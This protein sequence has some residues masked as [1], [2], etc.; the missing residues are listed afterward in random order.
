MNERTSIDPARQQK[1]KEI[2]RRLHGGA[3]ASEVKRDFADLIRGVSA[4]EVASMEQA[5][6]D[7]GFPVEE[8]QRLCEVHVQVFESSLGKGRPP[9][10][11]PGHPVHSLMAE[12]R[13]A[14][15]RLKRLTALTRSGFLASLLRIGNVSAAPG[16]ASSRG[17]AEASALDDLEKILIH[18]TRKENQLFPYLEKHGFTGPSKVM[19]GKHDEIRRLF[20]EARAALG[21]TGRFRSEA[22]KLAAAIRRMIFMEERILL[23]E[24]LRKLSEREWAEIRGGED[25]IGF[26]WIRP[27][28]EYDA[29]IAWN[30]ARTSSHPAANG[31]AASGQA[32]SVDLAV[33]RIPV[34]ILDIALKRLPFDLS[35]VDENNKV[36]Y[37]SDSPDRVFPRSP[38]VIGRDVRNC[39]P[40]SSVAV[41]EKI[42]EAFRRKERDRARFW[43]QLGERF[44]VIEYLALYDANGEYRGTLE[45]SQDATGTRALEGQRRLLEWE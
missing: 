15:T 31:K 24:S 36:L 8:I 38:A 39:H 25:A 32:A 5:L 35:I 7:E 37:Y 23:P 19:W 20:K 28:A 22:G 3:S 34:E 4:Q 21:D 42:I 11:M 1:L 6:V 45:V 16:S 40:P 2:I 13:E 44:V 26:A 43:I 33:G 17:A 9:K 12:N 10:S 30:S 29:G 18:Y 14:R 27:G 41:V